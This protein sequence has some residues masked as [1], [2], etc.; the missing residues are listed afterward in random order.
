[1]DKFSR[2]QE[3][4][5]Q[6]IISPGCGCHRSLLSVANIAVREGIEPDRIFDDIRANIPE[7]SRKVFDRE[8]QDAI[9]KALADHDKGT[10]TPKPKPA[11][12]VS[13]GKEALRKIINQSPIKDEADLW[14]LSPIRLNNEPKDD[15]SLFLEVVF[16]ENDLIWIDEFDEIGKPGENIKPVAEWINEFQNG[17]K[18]APH[19]IVNPLTGEPAPLKSDPDK[20]TYRGDNCISTFKYCLSEFD[21][22]THEEQIRF[23]TSIQLPIVALI[24]TGGKSI[25][26]WIDVQKLAP[27][28]TSEEWAKNIKSRLY[29]K[30]LTPLGID[31]ACAN[32]ARLSRLPGHFRE[33]KEK[34]QR[35]L[36]LSPEGRP[37]L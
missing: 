1:L 6:K 16:N 27:V 28:S 32:P 4:L 26:A 21:N 3:A 17:R 13:D 22:L 7:G 10:F 5:K 36:W 33:E 18:T 12:V 9:N 31:G 19:I 37:V 34:Y 15:P 35:L 14:E 29:D 25:H 11:P 2:Y 20:M 24:D 8:I 23:W 30:I